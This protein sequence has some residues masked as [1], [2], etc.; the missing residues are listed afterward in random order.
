M[1]LFNIIVPDKVD[2]DSLG[3][4]KYI[5][6]GGEVRRYHRESPLNMYISPNEANDRILKEWKSLVDFNIISNLNLL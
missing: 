1:G 2:Y 3:R 6:S 5:I 4:F